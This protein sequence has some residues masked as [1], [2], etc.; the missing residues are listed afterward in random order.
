MQAKEIEGERYAGEKDMQAASSLCGNLEESEALYEYKIASVEM[1]E[2]RHVFQGPESLGFWGR[3]R[4]F[5]G[6]DI[7][8]WGFFAI[9]GAC[10]LF[11]LVKEQPELARWDGMDDVWAMLRRD[12]VEEE[13]EDRLLD[14]GYRDESDEGRP[15]AYSDEVQTNKPL[16][17][18]PL[19]EKPLPAVPLIDA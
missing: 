19:P 7:R 5:F 12:T 11:L 8:S 18:K 15:P 6:M 9:W 2:R 16:P 10:K 4:R 17:S 1:M 13:E 3:I 14:G